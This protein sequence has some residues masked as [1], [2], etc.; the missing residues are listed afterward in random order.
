MEYRR[1]SG[2]M[3]AASTLRN[4]SRARA[5]QIAFA[6]A[7]RKTVIT[8][9]WSEPH[10]R[11]SGVADLYRSQAAARRPGGCAVSLVGRT[12]SAAVCPRRRRGVVLHAG[13]DRN[14]LRP[15]VYPQEW[16]AADDRRHEI[17]GTLATLKRVLFPPWRTAK[18]RATRPWC[19][20]LY[21]VAGRGYRRDGRSSPARSRNSIRSRQSFARSAAPY[22]LRLHTPC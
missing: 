7:E 11:R 19:T 3:A 12:C 15:D 4:P 1:N 2:G 10:R 17:D 9:A 13:P 22:G 18:G 16:T 6:S 21:W 8:P 5:H 14:R 20:G